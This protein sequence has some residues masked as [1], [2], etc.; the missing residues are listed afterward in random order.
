MSIGRWLAPEMRSR[1]VDADWK[2]DF[3]MASKIS[4]LRERCRAD[5]AVIR[6]GSGVC[7]YMLRQSRTV[8]ERATAAATDVRTNSGMCAHVGRQR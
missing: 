4:R 3:S 7:S 5:V 2:M 1:L 6:S 8:R